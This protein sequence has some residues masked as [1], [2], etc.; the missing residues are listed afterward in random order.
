MILKYPDPH[1][2]TPSEAVTDPKEWVEIIRT[3]IN[4]AKQVTWGEVKGIAAPQVGINK[5]VFIEVSKR[6]VEAFIYPVY[7]WRSSYTHKHKDGCYSLEDNKFDY[8]TERP[9]SVTLEWT[10]MFTGKRVSRRFN[11]ADAQIVQHE[12]DHLEGKM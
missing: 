2:T 11:D 7:L 12:M 1:L 3:L 9:Y 5:R 6:G 8:P 4:E 10:D